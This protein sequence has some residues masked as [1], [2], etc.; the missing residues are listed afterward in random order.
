MLGPSGILVVRIDA[1]ALCLHACEVEA[2]A[3]TG[4]RLERRHG[5]FPE[6]GEAGVPEGPA[7][8]SRGGVRQSAV[9]VSSGITDPGSVP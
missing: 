9:T 5:Q 4:G 6:R 3:R 1:T 7:P 8:L 2:A